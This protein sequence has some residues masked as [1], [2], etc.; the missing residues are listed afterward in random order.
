MVESYKVSWLGRPVDSKQGTVFCG[1]QEQF[2]S[3]AWMGREL[4]APEP[5]CITG[6]LEDDLV[7]EG[8]GDSGGSE[9]GLASGITEL[10]NGDQR[11]IT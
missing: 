1:G 3:G 11:K 6:A 4:D 7:A 10:A 9:D 8:D 5:I 2:W